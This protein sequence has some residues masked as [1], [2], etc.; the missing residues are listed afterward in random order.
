[1]HNKHHDIIPDVMDLTEIKTHF[2]NCFFLSLWLHHCSFLFGHPSINFVNLI[3]NTCTV[4]NTPLYFHFL[5]ALI[6]VFGGFP[7][8]LVL[9]ISTLPL[10]RW[11]T[12]YWWKISCMTL[13]G[14]F[15][16]KSLT[17]GWHGRGHI[18]LHHPCQYGLQPP[19]EQQRLIGD[20]LVAAQHSL[21]RHLHQ[22]SQGLNCCHALHLC[23]EK[24]NYLLINLRNFNFRMW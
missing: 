12:E 16:A 10:E 17:P 5:A 20:Q 6:S 21:T 1:M 18:M 15:C 22:Q 13:V 3:G 8:L 11:V 2:H 7:T 14:C 19:A 9:L 24:R 4:L 23:S